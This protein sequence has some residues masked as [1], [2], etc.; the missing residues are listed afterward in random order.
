M[1]GTL[2][3]RSFQLRRS[4]KDRVKILLISNACVLIAFFS[5]LYLSQIVLLVLASIFGVVLLVERHFFDLEDLAEGYLKM[6][7][8]VSTIVIFL[9]IIG[10]VILRV[11]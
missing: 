1:S 4:E 11:V 2:W 5:V 10:F 9:H 8:I 3:S 6:R 7:S